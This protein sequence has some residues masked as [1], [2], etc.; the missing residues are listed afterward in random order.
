VGGYGDV[1]IKEGE[2]ALLQ[3]RGLDKS[4]DGRMAV[5]RI[6]EFLEPKASSN[7]SMQGSGKGKE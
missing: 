5:F 3:A 4:G 7:G 1:V 2:T 6:Q